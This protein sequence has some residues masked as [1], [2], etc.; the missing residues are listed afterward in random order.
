MCA[1]IATPQLNEFTKQ[2]N[3]G[4]AVDPQL[5]PAVPPPPDHNSEWAVIE[6]NI[7]AECPT[8]VEFNYRHPDLWVKVCINI[9]ILEGWQFLKI[10]P[11][12]SD[13]EIS[14]IR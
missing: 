6:T 5:L 2:K 8:Q 1:K 12:L 7:H 10:L 3:L 14:V 13:H 4:L 9:A 11:K